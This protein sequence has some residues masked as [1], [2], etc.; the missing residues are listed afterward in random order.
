[1]R[2]RSVALRLRFLLVPVLPAIGLAACGT[3][4][5]SPGDTGGSGSGGGGGGSG[6]GGSGSGSGSGGPMLPVPERG[7][8]IVSPDI[9]IPRG[10]EQTW[11]YYFKMPNTEALP[12]KSWQSHMS[13]G[14]HHMILYTTQTELA[15]AG[16]VTQDG[17]GNTGVG[18][19]AA[20]WTYSAQTVDQTFTLPSDDGSQMHRALAQVI[21][22]G[23]PAFIQMHYLNTTDY[24][25]SVHVELNANAHAPGVS[26]RGAAPYVTYNTNIRLEAAAGST[27]TASGNCAVSPSLRFFTMSTHSH[28]QAV[29]T[30]VRDGNMMVFESDDWEHP[31][32]RHWEVAPFF[33][34]ASGTLNYQCDYLNEYGTPDP[35]TEGPSAATD[36]MCMAI[37]YYFDPDR[38]TVPSRFCLNSTAL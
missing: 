16:T 10:R 6:S 22:P 13:A 29:H 3:D 27:A 38:L 33:S 15:P 5:A 8:Q 14:S 21:Q 18:R 32:S 28:K 4:A 23:Q 7:F 25:M 17:C 26:Y 37:G 35:V 11:C 12:I 2:S 9:T 1:M 20:I 24:D 19:N 36:E 30:Y 34:F 31:G